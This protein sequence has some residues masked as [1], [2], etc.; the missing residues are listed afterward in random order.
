MKRH[1]PT[2]PTAPLLA[3]RFCGVLHK[4]LGVARV[5]QAAARNAEEPHPS[6]CH[7]HDFCD[8]NM[9]MAEAWEGLTGRRPQDCPEKLWDG[10][11]DIAKRAGFDSSRIS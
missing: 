7:S 6:I 8:A 3:I 4:W 11:W 1:L 2:L 10:A 9:A 5:Q